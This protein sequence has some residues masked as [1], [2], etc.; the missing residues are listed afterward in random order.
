MLMLHL[1]ANVVQMQVMLVSV[2][3]FTR[4]TH[5]CI[6]AAV[7]LV[8]DCDGLMINKLTMIEFINFE[9]CHTHPP[10]FVLMFTH[11]ICLF[12]WVLFFVIPRLFLPT[13]LVH[14]LQAHMAQN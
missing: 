5:D 12:S 9:V 1:C 3:S 7:L 13:N 6:S 14:W 11:Q 8:F 10:L 4:F 2:A